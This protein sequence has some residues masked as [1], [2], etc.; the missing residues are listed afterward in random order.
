MSNAKFLPSGLA[1]TLRVPYSKSECI[2]AMLLAASCGK[3]CILNGVTPPFC[4]DTMAGMNA[5]RLLGANA[6]TAEDKLIIAPGCESVNDAVDLRSC[7]SA[8]RMLLPFCMQ[9]PQRSIIRIDRGMEKRVFPEAN[10]I[11]EAFGGSCAILDSSEHGC[12]VQM[13]GSGKPTDSAVDAVHTSQYLSGALMASAADASR[14]FPHTVYGSTSP[15]SKPYIDLTLHWMRHFGIDVKNVSDGVYRIDSGILNI[16]DEVYVPGDWTGAAFILCA[17]A[18]G[19][20]IRV[21]GLESPETSPQGDSRIVSLLGQI[22]LRLYAYADGLMIRNP[23]HAALRPIHADL[24]DTPDLFPYLAVV[25]AFASGVSVLDGV[26]RL[27][28]KECNRAEALLELLNALGCDVHCMSNRMTIVGTQHFKG[29]FTFDSRGD[30]R[31]VMAAALASI[32]ADAPITVS[33]TAC[34]TKSWPTFLSDY[35]ALGGRME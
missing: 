32:A 4:D 25:C 24:S 6:Q 29:G 2:R 5:C 20:H 10:G 1:G 30:H 9:K 23:S 28:T 13:I 11:A 3:S 21:H 19:A 15:V 7:A 35:Q 33:N 27:I 26:Q 17:D 22:G 31:M 14:P 34:V 16:P 18:L 8:F 12:T